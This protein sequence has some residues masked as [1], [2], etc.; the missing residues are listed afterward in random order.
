MI[1]IVI[2]FILAGVFG[3]GVLNGLVAGLF[4]GL[5]LSE[6]GFLL[7]MLLLAFVFGY[8]SWI[9]LQNWRI[10]K[11]R[12]EAAKKSQDV[13]KELL[14]ESK[15]KYLKFKYLGGYGYEFNQGELYSFGVFGDKLRFI[16][17]NNE[18]VDIRYSDA[19]SFEIGG[20]GTTTTSAGV[21]GGGFGVEGFIKGAVTA[22]VINAATT[23]S[24]TN[25]LLKI[26]SK[27]GELFLHTSMCEPE[28]LRMMLSPLSISISNRKEKSTVSVA[29]EL[30]KLN[31][32]MKDGVI[33][34]EDF[35]SAKNKLL[36]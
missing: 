24:S 14:Y 20:T 5:S 13:T 3:I 19:I 6:M 25:T 23:K 8:F 36:S 28:E 18:V 9:R 1:K 27:N 16:S 32:L 31:G 4:K 10:L 15:H 2:G 33:T 34:E 22:A 7:P 12:T 11:D 21:S 30:A 17:V 29:D 26:T 35:Q